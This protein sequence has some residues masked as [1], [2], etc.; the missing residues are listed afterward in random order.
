VQIVEGPIE[1][2]FSTSRCCRPSCL[3]ALLRQMFPSTCRRI[4]CR[5][6]S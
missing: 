6:G 1:V 4:F 5:S 2:R 3:C